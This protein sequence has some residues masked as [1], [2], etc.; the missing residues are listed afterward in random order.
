MGAV[1]VEIDLKSLNTYIRLKHG[2]PRALTGEE[3]FTLRQFTQLIQQ[4]IRDRWPVDTGTSRD[5][6]IVYS[7]P[8]AG[9]LAIFVENPMFYAEYVNNGLWERLVPAVWNAVKAEVIR[10]MKREI[11][12]TERRL[13]GATGGILLDLLKALA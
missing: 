4:A 9:D 13:S 6:W 1:S 5:R 7:V 10:E 2:S 3:R 12:K 8:T 11:D